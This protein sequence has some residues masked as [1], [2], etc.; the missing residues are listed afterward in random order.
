[1]RCQ[2]SLPDYFKVS[3]GTPIIWGESGATGGLG[4]VTNTISLDA[5]A[6]GSARMGAYVDLGAEWYGEYLLILAIESGTAPTAGGLMDLYLSWSYNGS[7]FA[8]GVTGSDGSYP[9]DGD[10]DQWCKQ[11]GLPAYSLPATND[12]N[13]VQIG[14]MVRIRAKGRYVAPVVDNNWDQAIRDQTTNSDN[15]S[16]I[17]LIPLNSFV[18]DAA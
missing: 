14:Q 11:L 9:S 1:M 12:G 7:G 4:T 5:L 6:S 2:I 13:T 15:L 17:I 10:E 16:R 18:Q 3:Q 8:G